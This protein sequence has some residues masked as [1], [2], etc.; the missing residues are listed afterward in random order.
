MTIRFV[1]DDGRAEEIPASADIFGA[2]GLFL[3]R[4]SGA[5]GHFAVSLD[6]MMEME[7]EAARDPQALLPVPVVEPECSFRSFKIVVE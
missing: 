3:L 4:H 7:N 5:A 6:T 1:H 2:M